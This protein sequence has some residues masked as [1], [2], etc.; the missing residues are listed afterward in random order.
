MFL[1][2]GDPKS[3]KKLEQKFKNRLSDESFN[4]NDDINNNDDED[5]DN[6]EQNHRYKGEINIKI[7][8]FAHCTTGKDFLPPLPQG[9]GNDLPRI[10]KGG[11]NAK[12]DL[13]TGLPFAR[14]PPKF[15]NGPD[16]GYLFGLMNLCKSFTK[17][18]YNEK[19]FRE[20]NINHYYNQL[21]PDL[22]LDDQDIFDNIFNSSN[23]NYNSNDD[24]NNNDNDD[25][26]KLV[27]DYLST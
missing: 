23:Y 2:D 5:N 10:K 19:S 8:D 24:N 22:K 18:W 17:I 3:Q 21:L 27:Y 1:Y 4:I 6:T 14:F 16:I 15:N 7:I 11:Y 20:L 13:K 9:V 25:N 26:D 12:I